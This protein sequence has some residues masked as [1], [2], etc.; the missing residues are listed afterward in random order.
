M[1]Q[2]IQPPFEVHNI[3][4][5]FLWSCKFMDMW[6]LKH[7][8]RMDTYNSPT[9]INSKVPLAKRLTS[10]KKYLA[11]CPSVHTS[12]CLLAGVAQIK[13]TGPRGP[14]SDMWT[15]QLNNSRHIQN[16]VPACLDFMGPSSIFSIITNGIDKCP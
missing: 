5:D 12:T 15:P 3:L 4:C 1:N 8:I 11:V 13:A 7:T 6:G 16:E 10:N 2:H 14:I 9:K